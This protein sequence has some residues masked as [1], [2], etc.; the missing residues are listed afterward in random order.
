MKI[1]SLNM[2][3][4][5]EISC[6]V[7]INEQFCIFISSEFCEVKGVVP[8]SE[9]YGEKEIYNEALCKNLSKYGPV[10]ETCKIAEVVDLLVLMQGTR[11]LNIHWIVF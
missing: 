8:I 7:T 11:I 4:I 2:N 1:T 6:D 5:N 10:P 3:T 9:D